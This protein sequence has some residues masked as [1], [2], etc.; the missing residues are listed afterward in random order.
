MRS[1]KK[2]ETLEVRVSHT[3]KK[4]FA[5]RAAARGESMSVALRRLIAE[6][7][8]PQLSA[9]EVPMWRQTLIAGMPAAITAFVLITVSL[10]GVEADTKTDFKG[11]FGAKD[12]DSNGVIDRDELIIDMT[13]RIAEAHV[14]PI[15]EGTQWEVRWQATPEML[16]DGHM[17]FYDGNGDGAAT[18]KEFTAAHERKRAREFVDA[19]TDSSGFVTVKELADAYRLDEAKIHAECRLAIGMQSA[20]RAPELVAFLDADGDGVVSLREFIDH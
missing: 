1:E 7:A 14:P 20:A 11:L 16:A 17:D 15:C 10:V 5:A 8:V 18:L 6:D 19:D 13:R 2:S 4:A 9:K 12:A 3:E